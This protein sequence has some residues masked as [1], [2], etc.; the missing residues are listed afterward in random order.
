MIYMNT[1]KFTL[2]LTLMVAFKILIIF[3]V[4]FMVYFIFYK[5]TACFIS[6]T[7]KF[8][9]GEGAFLKKVRTSF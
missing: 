6:K 5:Q 2:A 7:N 4:R 9:F 1:L 3:I 8:L